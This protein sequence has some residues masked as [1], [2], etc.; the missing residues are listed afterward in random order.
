MIGHSQTSAEPANVGIDGLGV[1]FGDRVVLDDVSL[2]LRGGLV[3]VLGPN[4]AGKTSL[5]RCL[6]TVT[7]PTSGAVTVDGLDPTDE[8][9]RISIRRRLGYL[10]QGFPAADSS[11]VH[12]LVDHLAVLK[13]LRDDRHR[14]SRVA[15]VL[16]EVGLW[17][18][19]ADRVGEL[20]GGMRQRLGLAQ[21]LLTEP[22][23]LLLDEPGSGLDPEERQRLRTVVAARRTRATIVVSTHLTDDA[24]DADRV[25]VVHDRGVAF[26]GT[27]ADLARRATG[28][29]W[30]QDHAPT[31]DPSLRAVWQLPDGRHRCC[32]APPPDAA[33]VEPRLEDGY[34][35]VTSATSGPTPT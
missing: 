6:A 7:R 25:I 34:L 20:S 24:A 21:S 31:A 32:G 27:P 1:R 15:A 12:D 33:L 30:I 10:P 29:T 19:R 5:L 16:D 2:R 14:R 13:E 28:R 3:A 35:L 17:E 23:L 4:G 11:R 9:E 8:G 26:S 18:R 22:S